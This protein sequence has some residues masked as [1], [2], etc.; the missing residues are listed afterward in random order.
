M[1][2]QITTCARNGEVDNGKIGRHY[3]LPHLHILLH[4]NM[5]Y[6]YVTRLIKLKKQIFLKLKT[7]HGKFN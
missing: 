7:N 3:Y 5:S 4:M 1:I 6:M 2:M